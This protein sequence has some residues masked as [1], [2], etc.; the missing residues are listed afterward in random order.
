[1]DGMRVATTFAAR[2]TLRVPSAPSL[3]AFLKLVSW[4]R[5]AVPHS[6]PVT[7]AFLRQK[8]EE[9]IPRFDGATAFQFVLLH[10]KVLCHLFPVSH[11]AITDV[12]CGQDG[13]ST[14]TSA[15]IDPPG[16]P[17]LDLGTS[18]TTGL[19]PTRVHGVCLG[20]RGAAHQPGTCR[21]V[22]SM[23]ALEEWEKNK[24]TLTMLCSVK[25]GKTAL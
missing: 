14:I 5:G 8:I 20:A 16:H 9:E 7:S 23:L 21:V 15:V 2:R 13:S 3:Q 18:I 1:M 10:P 19:P 11:A 6:Q 12:V 17:M 4:P 24:V 25:H 22:I